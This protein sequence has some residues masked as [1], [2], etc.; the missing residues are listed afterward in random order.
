MQE[1]KVGA[2]CP[3]SAGVSPA[4]SGTVPVPESTLYDP[5]RDAAETRRRGRLR[6]RLLQKANRV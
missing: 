3:R 4:S 6:Y 1:L 5:R 2:G